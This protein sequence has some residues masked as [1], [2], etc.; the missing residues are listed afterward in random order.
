MRWFIITFPFGLHFSGDTVPYFENHNSMISYNVPQYPI[1]HPLY[2]HC[3]PV[4]LPFYPHHIPILSIH[5]FSFR[6]AQNWTKGKSA[7]NPIFDGK[8]LQVSPQMFQR[9][10]FHNPYGWFPRYNPIIIFAKHLTAQSLFVVSCP[11]FPSTG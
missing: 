11:V 7:G 1:T 9:I 4:M 5:L 3:I 10:H 8:N 6:E 2:P